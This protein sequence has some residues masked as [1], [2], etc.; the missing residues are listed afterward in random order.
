MALILI[1]LQD[2]EDGGVDVNV[3]GEPRAHTLAGTDPQDFT[4]AQKLGAVAL[5]AI[6]AQLAEDAPRILRMPQ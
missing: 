4:A 6:H 5:N 2:G 3:Q 1:R